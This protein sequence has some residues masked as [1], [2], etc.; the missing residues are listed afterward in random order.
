MGSS[1]IACAALL[2]ALAMA[3][4]FDRSGGGAAGAPVDGAV[5]VVDAAVSDG[6]IGAADA[7]LPD[8]TPSFD[9]DVAACEAACE[10]I[11]VCQ[12]GTCKIECGEDEC[13]GNVECPDGVPCS[14]ECTG[15]GS[16]ANEV[17]CG[18][19]TECTVLCSGQSSCGGEVSCGPGRCDVTC[20]GAG[21]CNN[22][23]DCGDACACDVDC[24]P[25]ACNGD[26]TC[27]MSC[28]IGDDCSSTLV[29][30]CD[31]CDL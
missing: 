1:R 17:V 15:T 21:S 26:P 10:G 23:V 28:D 7:A 27:K 19:A 3:C 25:G 18:G 13:S 5:A 22:S 4:S 6:A 20:S 9:A 2:A 24:Q 12:G 8:A 29:V 14:V 30:V 11:G 31:E 16:C